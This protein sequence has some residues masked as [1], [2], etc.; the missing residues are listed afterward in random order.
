MKKVDA[1]TLA[2][3]LVTLGVLGILAAMT[4]GILQN[5]TDNGFKVAYKKAYSDM[6]QAF[7]Q[8][9]QDQYLTPRTGVGDTAATTSE[10]AV[11]Q[12]AFKASKICPATH[13]WDCWIDNDRICV[14][15]GGSFGKPDTASAS[16]I[17]ASGSSWAQYS[18]NE[19]IYLVDTNGFKPPNKFG[20]DRW[21]FTLRNADNART[22][23]G[24]PSKVGILYTSDIITTA[25]PQSP[26]WCR[27]PPCYYY[28]W[29]YN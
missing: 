21:M 8:A 28:S 24:L 7:A 23:T 10:W 13:L 5:V 29:L 20:K 11:M 9:I 18:T 27:Y 16:F 25:D 17:D 14:G 3:V 26:N 12:N 15:C 1:F 22:T 4:I 19:N 6:S 2:E